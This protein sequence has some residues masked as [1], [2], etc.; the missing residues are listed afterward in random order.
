MKVNVTGG[1]RFKRCPDCGE[2]HDV[3]DWPDNHRRPDEALAAPNVITDSMPHIQGQHDG[4]WYDSKRAL[5][6]SYQPSGNRDGKYFVELGNDP[7]ITNP[8]P[9]AKPKPDRKGIRESIAKAEAKINRGEVTRETYETKV[10]T[11]P[12][13]I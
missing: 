6:A 13:P 4:K 8:K 7:S 3:H 11:R 12:G 9:R 2:M 1:L 5:R 10:L